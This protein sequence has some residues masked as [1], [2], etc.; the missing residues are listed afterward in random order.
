M[1]RLVVVN[2]RGVGGSSPDR[3]P[4]EAT[5]GQHADD[6]EAVRRR[7]GVERWAFWG[8][9]GG[10]VL[11]L[12]YALRHPQALGGLILAYMGPSGR[13]IAEDERSVLSPRYPPYRPALTAPAGA[14]AGRPAVLGDVDPRL[15]TAT[16]EPLGTGGW[17]L[18][19]HD[20]ALVVCPEGE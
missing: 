8:E 7:L 14:S 5:F 11:G 15:A 20:E 2:P 12:L 9:S 6:L 3:E 18:T 19:R 17:L 1:G 4:R 16:W 10:G 13:L